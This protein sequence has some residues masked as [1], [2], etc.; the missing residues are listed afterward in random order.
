MWQLKDEKSSLLI[1]TNLE[2]SRWSK[3]FIDPMLTAALIDR[4]T[5][6]SHII[7]MNGPSF[8]LKQR[9]QNKDHFA[10]VL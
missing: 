7:D 4:M 10:G 9:L 8:R 2:F 1:T 6:N 3:L 5:H